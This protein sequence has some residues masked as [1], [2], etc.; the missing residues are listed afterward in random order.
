MLARNPNH[1]ACKRRRGMALLVVMVLTMLIALG[2]YRYSF[3]MQSQYRVTRVHEEQVQ[4]KL[5]ALSGL[6]LA[7]SLLETSPTQRANRGGVQS[8][9]PLFQHVPVEA[10]ANESESTGDTNLWHVSVV[11]PRNLASDA[12]GGGVDST[13]AGAIGGDA[14]NS[15]LRF[16]LE[17]ESAKLHLPT[18]L[19]WER[20]FPGHARA[21][22]MRLPG[23]TAELIDAWLRRLGVARR[24][25]S[26][27]GESRLLD[28][29]ENAAPAVDQQASADALRF[30]W[31][32]GDLN[33]NYRLDP[34]ELHWAARMMS[35]GESAAGSSSLGGGGS[36]SESQLPLAWQ[37][38]L[39]WH[40]GQRNESAAGE[41]RLYLNEDNLTTLHQRLLQ[42]WPLEWAN[43]V[44]AVRQY[45]LGGSNTQPTGDSSSDT[46]EVSGTNW[47]PDFSLPAKYSLVSVLDLVEARIEVPA[48]ES[49]TES[50]SAARDASGKKQT[51]PNPFTSDIS[52]SRDY[53]GRLLNESTVDLAPILEGRVDVTEAPVEVLAGVPGIDLALAQAIVRQRPTTEGA[54]VSKASESIAW[55]LEAGL[56][57]RSRLKQLEPYLTSRSDVYSLQAVGYRDAVSPVC[58]CTAIIDARQ[59]P[60]QITNPQYWHPWDRG[61]SIETFS[62]TPVANPL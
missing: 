18:L 53:L 35:E 29:L 24:D 11:S 52:T 47:S 46:S 9:S 44:I 28:R 30:H 7:A 55:M 50:E 61:F 59:I 54:T 26:A 20:Q 16:G 60:A 13:A 43:Y 6:E 4:A 3:T 57:D 27:T 32:G 40:S 15:P 25:G 34:L 23:A 58:R 38:Y 48:T 1:G 33:Q 19:Q 8:N 51:L 45:G 14:A 21:T 49:T 39:T 56:V 42:V 36:T 17:N 22:L 5:A 41:P 10:S 2:A 37:R 62:L 31:L 12:N